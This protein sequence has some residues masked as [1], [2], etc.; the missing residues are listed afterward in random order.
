MTGETSAPP[1][2]RTT[3]G[4]GDL[5][6]PFAQ[7]RRVARATAVQPPVRSREIA[8]VAAIIILCDLTIYRGHGF[9]GYAMLFVALP[10]LF[11]WGAFRPR[12]G[13]AS[14][15]TGVMLLLLAAR[16]VW[17]GSALA[18]AAG[19]ALVAAFVMALSGQ[20]PFVA[21]TAVFAS[22]SI[23]SGYRRFLHYGRASATSSLTRLPLLNVGL[24]LLALLVFGTVFVLANPDLVASFSEALESVVQHVR[25]WLLHM[26]VG[27][28]AFWIAAAWISTGLL[29]QASSSGG[30]SEP[31]F[32]EVTADV[33]TETAPTTTEASRLYPAFRNTL[34]TV[35][36]LF[37]VYLV[38]EF[39]TLWFRE[40][41]KGFYYSGYAHEGAAWL[42][43][44][45][46][47]AT[48]FLSFVF[49]GGVLGDPRLP[50]LRR[51]GWIW[52]AE[53]FVL[54]AAVYHRMQIYVDFN[55]MSPMRTV[56]LF[57]MTAVVAGFVLVLWKI[58]KGRSFG[59]LVRRQLWALALTIYL[60][61]LTP[62]DALVTE[63]NVR[64]IMAGD[65]AASVQ[66]SV[67]PISSEGV[68]RLE[69]LLN[70]DDATI[71]EGVRALLAEREDEAELSAVRNQQLGWTT[72]QVSDE[73][74]LERLR[75]GRGRWADYRDPKLRGAAL[76]RFHDY[77][78]QWY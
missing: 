44:A 7:E 74:L 16:L 63:Y 2:A 31:A 18:V 30:M 41:P 57:G 34:V 46:A 23:A 1:L 6:N 49:R 43:F 32:P 59:W 5:S 76:K 12:A 68:L 26:S 28:V 9:A 52:S 47:L 20:T 37:A 58:A 78:Y 61:A 13:T 8:A 19:F 53:N 42:T 64:R 55:G 29:R 75:A 48:V 67:H 33:A 60:F 69:P 14:W 65:P 38:F 45:L 77:A 11:V 70:C 27:E 3:N 56:G 40:F 72:Y 25:A 62:V 21:E 10:V 15:T 4:N 36:V 51:L 50:Q 39:R 22:Q 66:I 71:R 35:I 17:C 73:I 24:P 54:A